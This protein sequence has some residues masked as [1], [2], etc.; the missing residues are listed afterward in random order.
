MLNYLSKNTKHAWTHYCSDAL[1]TEGK[2]Y[3]DKRDGGFKDLDL[4]PNL[5][6]WN[7]LWITQI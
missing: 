3:C 2:V 5:F 7:I 6:K 4:I 1:M